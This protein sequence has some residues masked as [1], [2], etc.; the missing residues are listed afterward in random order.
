MIIFW[1]KN[2]YDLDHVNIV[3]KFFL[4]LLIIGI[5]I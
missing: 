4:A 1:L 2:K 3:F 5:I